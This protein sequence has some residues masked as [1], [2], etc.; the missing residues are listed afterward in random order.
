MD[1]RLGNLDV[2]QG[3]I[4]TVPVEVTGGGVWREI[5]VGPNAACGGQP[6]GSGGWVARSAHVLQWHACMGWRAWP[7]GW[8]HGGLCMHSAL[9]MMLLRGPGSPV[10]AL[11]YWQRPS[12]PA[13]G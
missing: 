11:L 5:A 4:S 1:G 3:S 6:D 12:L 2:P 7:G 13:V 8:P 9:P 10:T